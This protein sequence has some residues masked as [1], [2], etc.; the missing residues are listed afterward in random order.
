MLPRNKL[1]SNLLR[2]CRKGTP[3]RLLPDMNQV[4]NVLHVMRLEKEE[5]TG[6]IARATL[7][8][9]PGFKQKRTIPHSAQQV[10]QMPRVGTR[11]IGIVPDFDQES[12]LVARDHA[13]TALYCLP[14][15]PFD[16]DL[17]ERNGPAG[18]L[19]RVIQRTQV[20]LDSPGETLP[21]PFLHDT[22]F[23][24]VLAA[25]GISRNPHDG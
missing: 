18:A 7:N 25:R 14:F 10:E 8:Q 16:I 3:V 20:D 19:H 21:L 2:G 22:R 9:S 4:A 13:P 12:R 11:L 5:V 1:K 24:K 23:I 17:D 15:M 6:L